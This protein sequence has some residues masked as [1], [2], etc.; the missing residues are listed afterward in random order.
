MFKQITNLHG[1]ELYLIISLW[2]FIVF[3][4]I[5]GMMLFF[6]KKDHV[7][8]RKKLIAYLKRK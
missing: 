2:I 3:F 7:R 4:V 6:M 5:V 8:W 1:D